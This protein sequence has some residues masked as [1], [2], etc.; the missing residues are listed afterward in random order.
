M[1]LQ[2]Q[3][4]CQIFSVTVACTLVLPPFLNTQISLLLSPAST[5]NS[6][7]T[8]NR[9]FDTFSVH[10]SCQAILQAHTHLF[11]MI[12]HGKGYPIPN[13]SKLQYLFLLLLYTLYNKP[14]ATHSLAFLYK[15]Q[16]LHS[17]TYW[18]LRYL[19]LC[20]LSALSE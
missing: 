11:S 12:L 4:Q 13:T 18:K 3:T 16:I 9:Y 1:N 17:Q 7:S 19:A 6:S 14:A 10:H 8:L 5:L 15:H 2:L 20:E